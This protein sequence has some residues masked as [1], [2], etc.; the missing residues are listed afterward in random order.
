MRMLRSI[1]FPP[2]IFQVMLLL[3]L[4]PCQDDDFGS[5]SA[6]I[7]KHI[8]LSYVERST[9]SFPYLLLTCSSV[10]SRTAYHSLSGCHIDAKSFFFLR[11]DRKLPSFPFL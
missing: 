5:F 6:R 10:F 2:R 7:W 4:I 1:S 8:T 3:F 9:P 11:Y